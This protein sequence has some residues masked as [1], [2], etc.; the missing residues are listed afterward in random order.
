[1][2]ALECISTRKSQRKFLRKKVEWGEIAAIL[3]AGR[4][5]PNAGNIQEWKFIVVDD[6]SK[7]SEISR[8]CID[9]TWMELAGV[10]IVICSEP[11][12]V[13]RYYGIRGEKLYSIQNCAAA[14]ENMLLA[15][16]AV[17]LGA[18]WVG[19]FEEDTV[20]MVLGIPED[21][22]PQIVIALGHIL[23]ETQQPEKDSLERIA[24]ANEWRK[25]IEPYK[26]TIFPVKASEAGA[27]EQKK[28]SGLRK[29]IDEKMSKIKAAF[30]K[31]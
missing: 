12:K 22:R 7:I 8:A 2:D 24:F 14:A 29:F 5:A 20:R 9:Q 28:N 3:D 26:A 19:A 21:V 17:G 15:A 13:E 31:K 11:L 10:L 4:A 30:G 16:H 25:K 23:E 6:G 18:C 27:K 1:M